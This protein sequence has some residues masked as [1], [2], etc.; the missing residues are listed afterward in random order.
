M[1]SAS[2]SE[3]RSIRWVPE[4]ASE[5]TSTLVLT[6]PGSHFVD[7]RVLKLSYF[8]QPKFANDSSSTARIDWAFA[9]QSHSEK[10]TTEGA[11]SHGRWE[12]WVDSRSDD[13]QVDEGDMFPQPS[14]LVLE[15]GR[16]PHPTTGEI[17]DYEE[18][19][20][21]LKIQ[22]TD[23]ED[24]KCAIVLR[25]AGNNKD[26]IGMVVR[27]GSWCQ[28]II[29]SGGN[30]HV[31]RWRWRSRDTYAPVSVGAII[32]SED[33]SGGWSVQTFPTESGTWERVVGMG[34]GTLPCPLTFKPEGLEQGQTTDVGDITWEVIER[35][36]W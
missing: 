14:G 32:G 6:S 8:K 13:P 7:I 33:D 3:R 31:E 16:G 27:V 21:D 12:H 9:G 10:A 35:S 34:R 2:I 30:L 36:E 24:K 23:D 4:P 25:T 11:A 26:S 5:P 15:K 20:R 29:K 18:T 1:P 17:T 28:G 19:W 22:S